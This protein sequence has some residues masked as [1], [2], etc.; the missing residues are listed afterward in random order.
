MEIKTKFNAN[1]TVFFLHM[2]IIQ[3]GEVENIMADVNYLQWVKVRYSFS[4]EKF[5][6]SNGNQLILDEEALFSSA[7]DLV[8]NL[9]EKSKPDFEAQKPELGKLSVKERSE[10]WVKLCNWVGDQMDMGN[11]KF[12][13]NRVTGMSFTIEAIETRKTMIITFDK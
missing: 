12:S 1:E 5:K 10:Q 13:L 4:K 7:E 9:L 8:K 6:T 11:N 3:S 2:G